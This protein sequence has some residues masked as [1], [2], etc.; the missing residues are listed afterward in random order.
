MADNSKIMNQ[1]SASQ[2]TALLSK[3]QQQF[4]YLSGKNMSVLYTPSSSEQRQLEF[5]PPGEAGSPSEP[6]PAQLPLSQPGIQVFNQNVRPIDILADYVS[7][8]AV[9]NDPKLQQW[10]QQF[11][12]S[13]NPEIMKQR[14]V[15][16]IQHEG[17]KRPFDEWM[18]MSGVPAYFRGYTFNQ[19]PQEFNQ[20]AY[21]PEQIK[22]LNTVRQYLGVK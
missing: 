16:A 14:Y 10:Y 19:W 2:G 21:T 7:H 8:Y 3:A 22:L 11:Q 13:L 18:K 5:Y 17:E 1:L 15:Y 4:P 12:S 6:R 9:S 20:K